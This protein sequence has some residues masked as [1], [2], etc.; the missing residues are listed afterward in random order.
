MLK[1]IACSILAA[2]AG[3]FF[4]VNGS[5]PATAQN[6][7]VNCS[8]ELE[9]CEAL[10]V[11]F[12]AKTGLKAAIVRKSAGETLAQLQAE[13]DNPRADVWHSAGVDSAKIAAEAGLLD[14]YQSPMLAELQDW[15]KDAARAS[16]YTLT[17]INLGA[18]GFG[19][20]SDLLAKK[21]MPEPKCWADLTNPI[22]KGEI[23]MADPSASATAY[24]MVTAILQIMGEQK[25]WDYLKALHPNI[26][27]YTR[28]GAAGI[29]AAGRGETAI[30]VAFLSDSL[31]QTLQ[32]FPVK[33][34]APC[35]GS[36]FEM[37]G[38]AMI[39]HAKNPDGAKKWIDFVLSTDGQDVSLEQ[40]KYEMQSNKNAKTHPLAP[41]AVI[42]AGY[43]ML[44]F[45]TA[46]AR[47]K[48]LE[49]FDREVKSR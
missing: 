28:S 8:F 20:N 2:G 49:K 29:R 3:L 10:R 41:T 12:E 18:V 16:N 25:G 38:V 43:D 6:V 26:N 14:S 21:K 4:A 40:K 11:K 47:N 27:Q 15:A 33:T 48:V 17:P 37:P 31:A 35:E 13:G 32:G 22:Y 46:D 44:K 5:N 42:P 36:G 23:Q 19:Y 34:V 7:V 24:V 9:W 1:Q 39:K 30:G 45:S